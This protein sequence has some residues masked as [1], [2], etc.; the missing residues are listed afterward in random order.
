M[1]KKQQSHQ[2]L[3]RVSRSL[4]IL[5]LAV[6]VCSVPTILTLRGLGGFFDYLFLR[7]NGVEVMGTIV[8]IRRPLPRTPGGITYRFLVQ[9]PESEEGAVAYEGFEYTTTAF[10]LD[11]QVGE[12]ITILYDPTNPMRAW[13]KN[14]FLFVQYAAFVPVVSILFVVATALKLIIDT[15]AHARNQSIS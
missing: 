14:N 3:K 2:G 7:Q 11:F 9:E 13:I 10:L 6:A 5:I 15:V 1:L 4:T 8:E 12:P